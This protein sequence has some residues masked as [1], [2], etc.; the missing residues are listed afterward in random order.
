MA[1]RT[2]P[3]KKKNQEE[4]DTQGSGGKRRLKSFETLNALRPRSGYRFRSDYIKVDD[5]YTTVMSFSYPE[6][7]QTRFATF[8]G[9][10][11]VPSGLDDDITVHV[12]DQVSRKSKHWVES[13]DTKSERVNRLNEGNSQ[14][15]GTS[16][17]IQQRRISQELV[18]VKESLGNGNAYLMVQMRLL[19]QAPTLE[20]LDKAVRDIETQYIK[21][22]S[23]LTVASRHGLQR[24]GMEEIF[25][26][27]EMKQKSA[28]YMPSDMYAGSYSLVTNGISDNDG[29]YIGY[30]T[31]DLNTSANQFNVNDYSS[32]VVIASGERNR[33]VGTSQ[34]GARVADMWG[35]KLSQWCL[36]HNGRVVHLVLNDAKLLEL[37]PA[38]QNIT[39]TVDMNRGEVNMFEL[40]GKRED[41]ITLYGPHLN[42]IALMADLLHQN[43]GD[44][45]V[46]VEGLL[47][48]LLNDFYVTKGMWAE[49][50]AANEDRLRMVGLNHLDVPLMHDF[51][52]YLDVARAQHDRPEGNKSLAGAAL[53]LS[54]VFK[55]L[56]TSYGDLFNVPTA[57]SFDRV[58][59]SARVI[60]DFNAVR[61]RDAKV[62]MAQLV[63]VLA[64]AVNSLGP[65]DSLFIH[66]AE[67]LSPEVKQYVGE[68]L[69]IL[70][71][72]G[73]RSVFIYSSVEKALADADYNRLSKVSYSVLGRM[74]EPEVD[75][76]QKIIGDTL[77]VDLKTLITGDD[78]GMTFVRRGKNNVAFRYDLPLGLNPEREYARRQEHQMLSQSDSVAQ[79]FKSSTGGEMQH[80]QVAPSSTRVFQ[81]GHYATGA[82]TTLEVKPAL[83]KKKKKAKKSLMD[84]QG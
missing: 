55:T 64:F 69:E 21:R 4:V 10:N 72:R 36:L 29:G 18:E 65:H 73:G 81:Q 47:K 56:L 41:Q 37:G 1:T 84:T 61:L 31:G 57:P 63:N 33:N 59:G 74:T 8:W 66:G 43:K 27:N 70:E 25:R 38:M 23:T 13:K 30:M 79:G 78:E 32:R 26:P 2:L 50:A 12:L 45:E 42:K 46:V 68:Q 20:K 14:N 39:A 16:Q 5:S 15:S 77:P 44:D 51:Q 67:Y 48:Q 40:F 49:N 52:A 76:Y 7:A 82:R 22:F 11:R 80:Q 6:G 83:V 54:M 9:V 19:V 17:K 62:A 60:Y 24:A 35:S 58:G 28:F 53:K 75:V 3:W 34:T 71:A